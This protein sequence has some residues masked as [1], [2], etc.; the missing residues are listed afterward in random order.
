LKYTAKFSWR[1]GEYRLRSAPGDGQ[2]LSVPHCEDELSRSNLR[3]QQGSLFRVNRKATDD[4]WVFRYYDYT[5]GER[6]YRKMTIGTVRE[7]PNRRAVE[8]AVTA[9]RAAINS[10]VRVPE[11]VADLIAHFRDHELTRNRRVFATIETHRILTKRYIEPI[12]GHYRLHA[13]RTVQVE[14][15]LDSLPLA[16]ASKT[17]IKSSFSLLFSHAIRHEWYALNPITKVRTSSKRLREKDVLSPEEFQA[18][19]GQLAVREQAMVLLVGTTG[20]RRSEMIALTWADVHAATLEVDVLRS[21]VRNR[22]HATKT[23]CSHRPVPLHPYVLNALLKWRSQSQHRAETDF[24][25]PSIRNSGHQPLSPDNIL[26]RSIRPALVRA[27][28]LGKQIGWHSFRHSLASNLRA[29]GVD[30]KVTQELLRHANCRT[31]LDLYTRAVSRQKREATS[32]VVE[33]IVPQSMKVSSAVSDTSYG[34]RCD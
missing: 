21:C 27:G 26:K 4:V 29:L 30:V 23:E 31:T 22:F 32:R 33:M 17:K 25:F 1:R 9:L 6:R 7:Y 24:L 19:L 18:L 16:P 15:W 28:I 11:T 34:E 12:W 3:Y 14:E 5:N 13:V 20:L 10:D 2:K 8:K